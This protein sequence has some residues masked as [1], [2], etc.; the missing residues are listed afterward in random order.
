MAKYEDIRKPCKAYRCME[1]RWAPVTD[2]LGGTVAMRAAREKW[3]P[4]ETEETAIDY[5]QRLSR[6][7]LFG[8]YP[9]AIDSLAS[10]PFSRAVGFKGELDPL[11]DGIEMD[12]DRAGTSLHDVVRQSFLD[13]LNYGKAHYLVDPAPRSQGE[14]RASFIAGRKYPAI[15]PI[16]PLDLVRWKYEKTPDGA[17]RIKQIN[18]VECQPSL[19]GED[20]E[21]IVRVITAGDANDPSSRAT[22]E[23]YAPAEDE[24]E[25]GE[26][27]RID[28]GVAS[29]HDVPLINW[30]A[31]KRGPMVSAPP[32]E[33]LAW[34][35]I[36]HWQ[37]NSDHRNILRFAAIAQMYATG[38]SAE[39]A[40]K[41]GVAAWNRFLHA[42]DPA[43][44]FGFVEHSGKAIESIAQALK[45]LENRMEILGMR[46]AIEKTADTTATGVVANQGG[47][48]TRLQSWIRSCEIASTMAVTL[49]HT[50]IGV[51]VDKSFKLDIFS[52][53]RAVTAGQQDLATLVT[54]RQNG[55]I[56]N[57]VFLDEMQRRGVL[58]EDLDV[59]EV[60]AKAA[61]D[62]E[63]ALAKFMASAPGAGGDPIGGGPGGQGGKGD[64]GG[65]FGGGP[66]GQ[67]DPLASAA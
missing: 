38:I 46:P 17:L 49:A 40:K 64:G 61:Q 21:E 33:Q 37:T 63:A 19:D 15:V 13:A 27:K 60:A 34:L 12:A 48:L 23:I 42:K 3:L 1:D 65:K 47:Q 32:L 6:S 31:Q 18:I 44:S 52:D 7:I 55:D 39:D 30:Y 16:S 10:K 14:T 59:A 50:L 25:K 11:L 5:E 66:G 9:D 35:N 8:A 36:A 41:L 22:W 56:P 62:K 24:D 29:Y 43:A 45:D 57:E 20:E 51:P 28:G 67:G 2:L 53:F 26:W 4:P 58:K 54:M